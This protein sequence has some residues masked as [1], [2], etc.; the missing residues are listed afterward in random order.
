MFVV[1]FKRYLKKND[2]WLI[3]SKFIANYVFYKNNL[4]GTKVNN[5]VFL[6]YIMLCNI[7]FD[8]QP[9]M[10]RYDTDDM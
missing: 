10:T 1:Y 4:N 8:L 3:F 9:M 6:N 7:K 2:F 5:I